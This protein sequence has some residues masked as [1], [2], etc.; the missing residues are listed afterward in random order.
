MERLDYRLNPRTNPIQTGPD[1]YGIR[2]RA[3][4]C[5][6]GSTPPFIGLDL[7]SQLSLVLLRLDLVSSGGLPKDD[8]GIHSAGRVLG[9]CD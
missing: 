1:S 4:K 7:D 8:L 5:G 9:P 3:I 6:I 2:I